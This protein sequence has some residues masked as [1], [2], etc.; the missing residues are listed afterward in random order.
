MND[1][2]ALIQLNLIPGLGSATIHRL[3]S[4]FESAASIFK[5]SPTALKEI[6]GRY[7]TEEVLNGIRSADGNN[8]LAKEFQRA[9]R[10]GVRIITLLDSDYPELLKNIS[11]PPPVLYVKGTLLPEDVAAV[12]IVGTRSATFYGLNV[13]HEMAR[14]L[15]QSGI[16][17]VSGLAEGIDRA[18]HEGSLEGSG[19]TLAVLGH[20]LNHLY[21]PSHQELSEEIAHSG[22]L[23]SEFPIDFP[24][25]KGN[26]PRRNRVIAGLS[27]GVVVV[28]APLKSGALITAR[29]A[30][31]QGREVFA[32]PGPVSSLKSKGTHQLLKDG[33]RLAESFLDV[34]EELAPV[35]K[36]RL[37]SWEKI[38]GPIAGESPDLADVNR[39]ESIVYQAIPAAGTLTAD[40][41]TEMTALNP[42]KLLT[43]LTELELK[44]LIRQI[45]GQ[46]YSRSR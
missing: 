41:L 45:P 26:F 17:V 27:L 1:R 11:D 7:A 4:S 13:A 9:D 25:G 20:G 22:A 24:P 14:E 40:S 36:E 3:L 31:E 44:G 37:S 21:P 12:A 33:A 39:E 2:E 18:A 38:A 28:E 15:A 8:E 42:A 46:G 6:L 23:V 30:L 43:L 19:R 35:L 16:T 5:A 32:V 34:I 10:S 29:E